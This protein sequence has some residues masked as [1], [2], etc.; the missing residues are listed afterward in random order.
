MVTLAERSSSGSQASHLLNDFV[1]RPTRFCVGHLP[2]KVTSEELEE[3]F[4]KFGRVLDCTICQQQKSK[5]RAYM[6]LDCTA[7]AAA[8]CVSQEITIRGRVVRVHPA[9][10]NRLKLAQLVDEPVVDAQVALEPFWSLEQTMQW[11]MQATYIGWQDFQAEVTGP[12]VAATYPATAPTSTFPTFYHF[13]ST[14]AL[15][16]PGKTLSA[17]IA[18]HA[19]F[20]PERPASDEPLVLRPPPR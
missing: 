2:W 13:A 14:D 7:A 1:L 9:Y 11:W 16:A 4:A 8:K 10:G 3:H 17:V 15:A 19:D 12:V 6:T 20:L 18:K 5:T